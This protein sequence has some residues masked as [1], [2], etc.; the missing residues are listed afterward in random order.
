MFDY[1]YLFC[2]E[3]GPNMKGVFME[4]EKSILKGNFV[5]KKKVVA[6]EVE[7]GKEG[8]LVEKVKKAALAALG[9]SMVY[10]ERN[11][12]AWDGDLE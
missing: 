3:C 7:G 11:Q 5:T 1:Q 8:D 2:I 4:K 12:L 6:K 9:G 10:M